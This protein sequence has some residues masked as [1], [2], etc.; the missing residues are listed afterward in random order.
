VKF[1]PPP[2][3]S[4][5]PSQPFSL[6]PGAIFRGASFSTWKKIGTP[7]SSAIA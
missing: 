1:S 3:K 7:R 2:W 5:C 6:N 4:V